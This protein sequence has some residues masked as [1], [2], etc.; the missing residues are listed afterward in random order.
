M[1]APLLIIFFVCCF[2]SISA[3][4]LR[5]DSIVKVSLTDH[6]LE[7]FAALLLFCEVKIKCPNEDSKSNCWEHFL[8]SA[9]DTSSGAVNIPWDLK[10]QQGF[11]GKINLGEVTDSIWSKSWKINATENDTLEFF[12]LNFKGCLGRL[13][14]ASAKDNVDWYAIWSAIEVTGELPPSLLASLF[15]PESNNLLSDPK[16]RLL[17]TLQMMTL[18]KNN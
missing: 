9:N 15:N 13:Y 2:G 18:I 1:R 8:T 14:S 6:E 4:S 16:M 12:N 3:Q 7:S 11:V 17:L 10:S 5:N